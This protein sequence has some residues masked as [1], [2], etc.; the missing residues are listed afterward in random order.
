MRAMI[1]SDFN[2]IL[3]PPKDWPKDGNVEC[4]DLHVRATRS[5]EG[6]P[7]LSSVWLPSPEELDKLKKGAPVILTLL[8]QAGHPPV[9]VTVGTSADLK[10]M[11]DLG[12][13]RHKA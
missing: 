10:I 8:T 1:I 7:M 12:V 11:K 4:V 2:N 9:M 3:K 5:A 6:I 13:K